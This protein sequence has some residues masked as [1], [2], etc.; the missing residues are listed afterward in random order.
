MITPTPRFDVAHHSEMTSLPFGDD[1]ARGDGASVSAFTNECTWMSR[2]RLAM[3]H[4]LDVIRLKSA[5]MPI[6]EVA[7]RIG[8]APSTA[9]L[10][11]HRFK[12]AGLTRPLPEDFTDPG[13]P[14]VRWRRGS[15]QGHRLRLTCGSTASR[16]CA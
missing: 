12:A 9:R 15:K 2:E 6:R 8:A 5:G 14:A 11:I 4:M 16:A 7:R 3:H 13:D 1:V 10:T